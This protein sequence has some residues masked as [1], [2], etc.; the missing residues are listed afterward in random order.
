MQFTANGPGP[1]DG[2]LRQAAAG[3]TRRT[4]TKRGNWWSKPGF[5]VLIAGTG[6]GGIREWCSNAAILLGALDEL[7]QVY[8]QSPEARQG[9]N[10]ADQR[11]AHHPGQERARRAVQHELQARVRHRWVG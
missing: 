1:V 11:P 5:Y 10:P 4:R 9:K 3:A 7:Y 2:A 6:V 8:E